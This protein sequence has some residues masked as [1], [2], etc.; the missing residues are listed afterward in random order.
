MEPFTTGWTSRNEPIHW[1]EYGSGVEYGRIA[2]GI[3]RGVFLNGDESVV[4]NA[5]ERQIVE[6][7]FSE[8][9]LS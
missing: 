9:G 3:R 6:R 8:R 2:D 5:T 4:R 1:L 7:I